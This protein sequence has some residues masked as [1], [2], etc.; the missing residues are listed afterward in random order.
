MI[1]LMPDIPKMTDETRI[2]VKSVSPQASFEYIPCFDG[3]R[4]I[5]ISIVL[6]RHFEVSHLIPG[7][8]GVTVFFFISGVLITRLLL[9]EFRQNGRVSLKQFYLR[10]FV[11]LMPALLAL[12]FI[13]SMARIA[14][15]DSVPASELFATI[16]YYRNYFNYVAA[17]ISDYDVLVRGWNQTWSLSIEEHF[18]FLFPPLLLWIGPANPRALRFFGGIVVVPLLLRII[19]WFIVPSAEDYNYCA[20]EARIDSILSGSLLA[21]STQFL[22]FSRLKSLIGNPVLLYASLATVV[23]SI[24]YRNSF[25]QDTLKFSIHHCCLFIIIFQLLHLDQHLWLKRLLELQAFRFAGKISYSLY[26]WHWQ[27]HHCVEAFIRGPFCVRLLCS[28]VASVALAL[29]SF[30]LIEMPL[31]QFRRRL[32]KELSH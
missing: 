22:P 28:I 3:L 23:A 11:R 17:C 12:V 4:A 20:T 8:F 18:Y 5:S 1:L 27:A 10:R 30:Y 31:I 26:L 19:Y 7:G 32:S 25:F 24:A 21:L 16:F 13:T 15:G 9:A 14:S 6:L 29:L 2:A